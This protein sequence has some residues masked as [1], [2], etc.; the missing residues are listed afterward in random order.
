MKNNFLKVVNVFLLG[1]GKDENSI[2]YFLLNVILSYLM[3]LFPRFEE[4][5]NIIF[6]LPITK[7]GSSFPEESITF[8]CYTRILTTSISGILLSFNSISD[9]NF[10]IF[11]LLIFTCHVIIQKILLYSYSRKQKI[12]E[13]E[14]TYGS[15]SI[16]HSE[17]MKE[18]GELGLDIWRRQMIEPLKV[19]HEI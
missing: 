9:I 6:C 17:T 19:H 8:T 14:L 5:E 7:L 10:N 11:L 4:E 16:D 18:I 2:T 1:S 13:A 3:C 15:L 12:S